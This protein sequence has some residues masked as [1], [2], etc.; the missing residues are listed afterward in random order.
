M[1]Y[2]KSS[3][4]GYQYSYSDRTSPREPQNHGRLKLSSQRNKDENR[5]SIDSGRWQVLRRHEILYFRHHDVAQS[6]PL[7]RAGVNFFFFFVC[8]DCSANALDAPTDRL[9]T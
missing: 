6:P 5:T 3:D 4:T 2:L 9:L 8:L 7:C 1:L